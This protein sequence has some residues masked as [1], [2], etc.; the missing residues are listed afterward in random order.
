MHVMRI[1]S[2]SGWS[3]QPQPERQAHMPMSFNRQN[4]SF[5][6]QGSPPRHVS[7]L[8]GLSQAMGYSGWDRP[9]QSNAPLGNDIGS[10]TAPCE[11]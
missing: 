5:G 2:L 3:L 11:T 1:Q 9:S 8:T 6:L 7:A 4:E 10:L